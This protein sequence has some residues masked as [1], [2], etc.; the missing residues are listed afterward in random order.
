MRDADRD[1]SSILVLIGLQKSTCGAVADA[2]NDSGSVGVGISCFAGDV[3]VVRNDL[4][5]ESGK[6]ALNSAVCLWFRYRCFDGCE[7]I[8]SEIG[9]RFY[10]SLHKSFNVAPG[11]VGVYAHVVADAGSR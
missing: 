9:D 1:G 8:G 6:Q 4:E 10:P 7:D 11:S 3:S 5:A 2:H